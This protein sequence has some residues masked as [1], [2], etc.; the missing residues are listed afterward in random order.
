[1][2]VELAPKLVDILHG[3]DILGDPLR[4]RLSRQRASVESVLESPDDFAVAKKEAFDA[5]D[6]LELRAS[7]LLTTRQA[8]EKQ[9]ER[10]LAAG[11]ILGLVLPLAGLVLNIAGIDSTWVNTALAGASLSG[12]MAFLFKPGDKLLALSRERQQLLVLPYAFRARV[13]A[14]NDFKALQEAT[15][16][17]ADALAGKKVAV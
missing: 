1:M 10:L 13:A 3:D 12:I 4:L 14:S 16:A 2:I 17:L 6:R 8:D 11:G 7:A 9:S 15:G 5:I